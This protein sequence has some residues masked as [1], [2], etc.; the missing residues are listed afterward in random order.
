MSE[1]IHTYNV[2]NMLGMDLGSMPAGG[3]GGVTGG[4]DLGLFFLR[5]TFYFHFNLGL[6][7]LP[8]KSVI[9]S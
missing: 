4:Q 3:H 7:T 6:R 5:M 1:S 9:M 2:G 8:I